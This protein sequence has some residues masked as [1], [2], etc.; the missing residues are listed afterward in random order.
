M[1]AILLNAVHVGTGSIIAAGAV[2]PEGMVI[3]PNSVVA[4]VPGR[5][6]RETRPAER[7]RIDHTVEA[8]LELQERHRRGEVPALG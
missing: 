1:G 5:V 8:Y 4:G 6:V 2:C 7:E 3:P